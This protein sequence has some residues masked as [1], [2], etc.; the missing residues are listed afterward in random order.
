VEIAALAAL[1]LPQPAPAADEDDD[2]DDFG[3]EFLNSLR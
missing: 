1:D 3:A 2:D